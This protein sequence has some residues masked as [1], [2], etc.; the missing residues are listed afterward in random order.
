MTNYLYIVLPVVYGYFMQ[1]FCPFVEPSVAYLRQK[2]LTDSGM[3]QIHDVVWPLM[4]LMIGFSWFF[5]RDKARTLQVIGS[6]V[7]KGSREAVTSFGKIFGK[8]TPGTSLDM[9]YILFT[10]FLGW[11]MV[12][13]SCTPNKRNSML[14]LFLTTVTG[15]ML[16]YL[17]T[18]FG[19]KGLFALIP[20]IFW[21]FFTNE[22][23]IKDYYNSTSEQE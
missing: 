11:W 19:R 14:V 15:F 7:T 3:K 21:L 4:Y 23:A 5:A 17:I 1:N 10:L 12:S 13:H 20:V 6:N 9:A 18:S 8:T 16:L 2:E 22:Q